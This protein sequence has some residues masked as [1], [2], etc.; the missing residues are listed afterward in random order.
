MNAFKYSCIFS[1]CF[2]T[3]CAPPKLN[4]SPIVEELSHANQSKQAT[5]NEPKVSAQTL[6]SWDISGAMAARNQKKGWSASLHWAQQGPSQY[7]IRLSGPLGGG[8]VLIDKQGG[9]VTYADGPKRS[10]SHNADELLQ[11]QTGIRLPVQNLYYWVR[12]LT[13][14]GSVQAAQY[15]EHHN[16]IALSQAGYK[17]YYTNYSSINH[18][19]L[20]GKVNLQGNG[21]VIKLVIKRWNV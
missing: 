21:V 9:V 12:G 2:L 10:S 14:P 6:S 7:H 13:A 1:L 11:Q 16:L 15:D 18:M 17:I 19:D 20:P 4:Q 5:Q 3:A 8:T